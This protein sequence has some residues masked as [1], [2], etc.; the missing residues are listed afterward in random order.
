MI[1]GLTGFSGA[2]KTTVAK[3]LEQ[4]GFYHLDCDQLV[5]D[6]VY[7]DPLLIASV[8]AAFGNE[9][10]ENG[11]INRKALREKTFGDPAAVARLNQVMMPHILSAL[12]A[13]LLAHQGKKILLDAPLLFE[14]GLEQKCDRTLAV[15]ADKTTALERIMERDGIDRAAAEKRLAS[16]NCGA[17]YKERCDFLIE[18]NGDVSSLQQQVSKILTKL[19]GGL[20]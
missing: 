19:T 4:L 14:Y 12:E 11:Q 3:I 6:T 13:D 10:L 5:H 8:S 15:V 2:G 17:Y 20:L 9:V 1:L 18:N 7:K 16:Q